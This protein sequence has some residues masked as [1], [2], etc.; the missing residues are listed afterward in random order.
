MRKSKSKSS[1]MLETLEERR[2]MT[3]WIPSEMSQVA[4][5]YPVHSG[6]TNLYL[7]FDGGSI[8]DTQAGGSKTIASYV[9]PTGQDRNQA[10]EDIIY[11]TAEIFSPF[12]VRV[13]IMRGA[14]NFSK[15]NGDTT[16][17]VGDNG[18]NQDSAGHNTA[19]SVTPNA[20]VDLPGKNK[21]FDHVPNSDAYDLAFVDAT[22]LDI[23]SQ[24]LITDSDVAIA[25]D[26]AHEAGH[27]FGLAHVLSSPQYDIMSYDTWDNPNYLNAVLNITDLNYDGASTTHTG[28]FP[29]INAIDSTGRVFSTR[30]F[31]QNS[32]AYLRAAL[33]NK[34]IDIDPYYHDQAD[35]TTVTSDYY[36]VLG[37]PTVINTSSHPSSTLSNFGEYDVYT[38]K[39]VVSSRFG[40]VVAPTPTLI[41][42]AIGAPAFDPQIMLYNSDGTQL[43]AA[44]HGSSMVY[45][46]GNNVNYKL[47]ISGYL[48]DTAGQYT[49]NM[50]SYTIAAAPLYPTAPP[51][52]NPITPPI[53]STTLL[54]TNQSLLA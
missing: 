44:T 49:V 48:G 50:S 15:T 24:V 22:H 37:D 53:F 6:T 41:S 43:L 25:R 38:L 39:K 42:L 33:G 8:N 18:A 34:A 5:H 45:M 16:I 2:L 26:I 52:T 28:D 20:S 30:I 31:Q 19:Y 9:A 1:Q 13:R 11:R 47:V 36:A 32:F 35:R 17:F 54:T 12:N 51:V 10:I 3:A 23:P 4:L 29:T 21:G 46:L 40:S 27:T 14:G 7:N